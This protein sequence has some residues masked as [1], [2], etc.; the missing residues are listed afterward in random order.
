MSNWSKSTTEFIKISDFRNYLCVWNPLLDG[1]T[2]DFLLFHHFGP[3]GT[4]IHIKQ[5]DVNCTKTKHK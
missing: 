4:K 2:D 3:N 5:T 1:S